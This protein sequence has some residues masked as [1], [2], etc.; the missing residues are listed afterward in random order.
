[1]K[2]LIMSRYGY[3][4]ASSRV[5]TYQYLSYIRESGISVTVSPLFSNAY[6]EALY[7]KQS[8][9]SEVMRGY[10]RRFLNIFTVFKYDL[11]LIEKE[12]FPF[13]PAFF[14]RLLSFFKI[15]Y[16]VDYDDAMFHRYDLHKS[17]IIRRFLGRKIDTVMRNA[18][19]VI[20]GNSYL[21]Q[22]A[23]DAGAQRVRIIP[24]VVDTKHYFNRNIPQKSDEIT[25]GWI[26]TPKTSHYLFDLVPVFER[27]AKYL[28]VRFVAIGASNDDFEGTL[29]ECWPWTFETEV[30]LI[31]KL[32][33]GIMPLADSSWERGKC[34]Y[35]LIQYMACG[36]PV[37]A[38][39]IGVNRDI[40]EEDVNGY[41]A[42]SDSGWEQALKKLCDDKEMRVSMGHAAREKVV[43]FYSLDAQKH[44]IV[45]AIRE[46]AAS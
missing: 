16:L 26:G 38:S 43:K 14:E 2:I 36:L 34:G 9:P 17:P 5:R 37:I 33:I 44:N 45:S 41:L 22:R 39:P 24:S 7:N 11:V 32:D 20:A 15:P 1:M 6:L 13:M 4:G 30:D 46:A 40:V 31:Q 21:A 23:V 8:S 35:K 3:L 12:L 10:F 28:K 19:V 42:S 27:L 18:A 25:V 29:I